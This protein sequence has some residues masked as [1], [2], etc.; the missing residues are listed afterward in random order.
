MTA[1]AGPQSGLL[2][3]NISDTALWAAVYR[4]RETERSDALFRDPFARRLAGDRGEQIVREMP[5][6]EKNTWSWVARTHLFDQYILDEIRN[7]ADTVINLAAGLDTRPY[8]LSLP[9][10]LQWIE[11]DLPDLIAYKES[12]LAGEKPVCQLGRVRLDLANVAARQDLFARVAAKSKRTVVVSEGLIIYLSEEEVAALARDLAAHTC[13]QRWIID[14]A[15][16]G[17]VRMLS[18]KMGPHLNKANAPFKFAPMQGAD[19]FKPTGWNPI[20]ITGML[21]AG[22]RLK[23]LPRFL[24]IMSLLPEPKGPP[25]NRPWGGV[26]VL[27]RQA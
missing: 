18:K 10:T 4:A 15:S 26:C 17:L 27:H 1:A 14:L 8:R 24:K 2:I 23:R 13:F 5:Y 12:I 20:I 3:R 7:G 22:A 6:G 19:F 9:P 11:V 25:G 21:K 16:P